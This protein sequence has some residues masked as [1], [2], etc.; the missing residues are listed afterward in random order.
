ML[1]RDLICIPR[2]YMVERLFLKIHTS[3]S[4][5]SKTIKLFYVTD[6]V[7]EFLYLVASI[8]ARRFL[9]LAWN[10][11][12]HSKIKPTSQSITQRHVRGKFLAQK[13]SRRSGM[14]WW[15]FL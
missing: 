2:G 7:C 13:K 5:K 15:L 3:T 11:Q 12:K 14:V 6:F 8:L 4:N 9:R 1:A 10:H